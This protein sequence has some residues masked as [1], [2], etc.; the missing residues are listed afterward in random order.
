MTLLS[1]LIKLAASL[2]PS[3]AVEFEADALYVKAATPTTI[4]EV[5]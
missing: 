4:L 3:V 2:D 1:S 5:T